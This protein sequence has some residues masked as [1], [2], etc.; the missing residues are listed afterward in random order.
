[1]PV[2]PVSLLVEPDGVELLP[3]VEPVPEL[4]GEV[5]LPLVPL[6]MVALPLAEPETEPDAP[7]VVELADGD[8]VSVEELVVLDG[9][10]VDDGV[11][12]EVVDD[13]VVVVVLVVELVPVDLSRSQPV[14]AAEASARAATRGRIFFMVAPIR[15]GFGT[16]IWKGRCTT[17]A[18]AFAP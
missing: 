5:E 18:S 13:G 3:D 17:R 4:L 8:V 12:D 6:P 15:T 10:V 7:G 9:V 14:T 2:L 16:Y 1:M 11:V